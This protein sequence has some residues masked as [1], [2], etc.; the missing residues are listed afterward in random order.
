MGF[1]FRKRKKIGGLR[2]NFSKKGIGAS[3]GTK[4]ARYTLKAGGGTTKT[5]GIPGTGVSFVS[6]GGSKKRR[7]G[8]NNAQVGGSS[9]KHTPYFLCSFVMKVVGI[10]MLG[11]CALLL[12]VKPLVG[13]LGIAA[14]VIELLLGKHWK[15][16][17]IQ[18]AL[19]EAELK[20]EAK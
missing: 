20:E 15:K 7:K 6:E 8:G 14:G 13:I 10:F 18:Q 17:G 19:E 5:V 12:F 4:G 16:K 3:V 2:I 1:R 9:R 11:F